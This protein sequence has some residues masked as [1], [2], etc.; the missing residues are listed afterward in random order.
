MANQILSEN[1]FWQ[2]R[3]GEIMVEFCDVINGHAAPPEACRFRSYARAQA[4]A[5]KKRSEGCKNVKAWR[6]V[7]D[8]QSEPVRL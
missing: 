7:S 4:F 8:D 5:E 6:K 3:T 2:V 1:D